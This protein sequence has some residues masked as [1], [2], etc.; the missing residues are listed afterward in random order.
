M[1]RIPGYVATKQLD[2]RT[3]N[4]IYIL[5]SH[6]VSREKSILG[7]SMFLWQLSD[8]RDVSA[9]ITLYGPAWETISAMKSVTVTS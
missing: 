8:R 4:G 2:T 5:G 3:A 9:W 6:N 7:T 1:A